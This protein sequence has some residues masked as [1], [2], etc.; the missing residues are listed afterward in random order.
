MKTDE[1]IDVLASGFCK[2]S[3]GAVEKEFYVTALKSLVKL[4]K[5]EQAADLDC[6]MDRLKEIR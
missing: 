2:I 4:A 6:D 5:S 3:G 1:A